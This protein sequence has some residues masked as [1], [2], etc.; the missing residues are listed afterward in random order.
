MAMLS[1]SPAG[2]A[3]RADSALDRLNEVM[4][5]ILEAL[6]TRTEQLCVTDISTD[7]GLQKDFPVKGAQRWVVHRLAVGGLRELVAATPTDILPANVNRLGGTIVNQGATTVILTL[8]TAATDAAQEGLAEIVL[9]PAGG[10]WDF[11]LGNLL[12]CGSVSAEALAGA[13]KVTVAEV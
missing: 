11:R 8:A 10:S 6:D 12:W 1:N 5:L 7:P 3:G 4:D 2:L 9:E 13:G